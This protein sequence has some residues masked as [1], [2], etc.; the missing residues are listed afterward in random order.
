MTEFN[1]SQQKAIEAAE[2]RVVVM[3]PAG[4]GKTFCMTGAIEKY[5]ADNPN[6]SIVAITFTRKAA[7]ELQARITAP[8]IE[9]S[10]IHSWAYRRL[11]ALGTDYGFKVQLLEEDVIK[12]ILKKLCNRTRQYYVNQFQLFSYVMGN[13]NIDIEASVRRIYDAIRHAYIQYK[14]KNQLYDFTDLPKYLLDKLNEYELDITD[15]DALFVDEFQD[16]DEIQLELFD[17]A[18]TKRKFYIGDI[19]QA[20]YQFRGAITGVFERL[21]DFTIYNLDTNYR[22][23]Q[24]II[25]AATSIREYALEEIKNNRIPQPTEYEGLFAESDIHCIRGQHDGS[26]YIVPRIGCCNMILPDRMQRV[27]D[28]LLIKK[29]LKDSHTQVLCRANKQ[30][31]KLQSL[32]IDRVSTVHQAKGLEYDNVILTDFP[33]DCEEELNIAYVG[34][35]RAKNILCLIPFEVLCYIICQEDIQATDRL[36]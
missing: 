32:S 8:G 25:N 3:A 12:E 20:I 18:K 14:E 11:H 28:I 6:D 9:I 17:R 15:I 5:R 33:M 2:P 34:M 4:S 22:S 7:A 16:I 36:F 35:T 24:D 29:L 1:A 21:K 10:T 26:V 31:R 19:R 23:Y 27:S 13:Y 30:V